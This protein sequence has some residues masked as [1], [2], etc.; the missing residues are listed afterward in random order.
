MDNSITAIADT[1]RSARRVLVI[2]GA[3]IS[4]DSGLPTYRGIGGLYQDSGT[5]D[6]LAIEDALSGDMLLTRPDITWKYVHQIETACRGAHYNQAHKILVDFERHWDV[7]VLTQNIDRFHLEAGSSNVIDIHGDIHDL[8]CMDCTY[9]L[10]V[11]DYSD[12]NLPPRCPRCDGVMRPDVVLFGEMLGEDKLRRLYA[13]MELGF[14]IVFSVGTTSVFP[15]IAGPV[16]DASRKGVCTV[17]INPEDTP[18]SE[19]V[20][21]HLRMGAADALQAIWQAYQEQNA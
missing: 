12:L 15:Y 19:Y 2:S 4:V 16:I 7:C 17:E 21:H 18:V 9:N 8:A 10:T 11:P 6:N 3:G 5:D 1:L 14:D 20:D 13:E